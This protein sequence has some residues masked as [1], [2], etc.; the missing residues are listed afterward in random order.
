MAEHYARV[1]ADEGIAQ[2]VHQAEWQ[3]AINSLTEHMARIG[4]RRASSRQSNAAARYLLRTRRRMVLP[5]SCQTAC[6]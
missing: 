3:A 1:I 4:S 5:T 6:T 2:K